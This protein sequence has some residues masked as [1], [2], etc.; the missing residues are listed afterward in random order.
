MNPPDDNV[1]VLP[2][3]RKPARSTNALARNGIE[4][5]AGIAR[6]SVD[7]LWRGRFAF[8]KHTDLSGDPGDGKSLM[9]GSLAAQVTRGRALPCGSDQIREPRAVLFLS[10]EDDPADTIRPRH[11]AAGGDVSLLY[12]QTD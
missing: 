10:A 11:E 5:I 2:P 9:I 6:E 3:Q 1:A 7:W 8:G 4:P 12:V